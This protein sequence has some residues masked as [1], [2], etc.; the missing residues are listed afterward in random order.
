MSEKSGTKVRLL[1]I[2]SNPGQ[3]GDC[4][5]ESF[6]V[7]REGDG[8]QVYSN[9]N[10]L[11]RIFFIPCNQKVER[12]NADDISCYGNTSGTYYSSEIISK[13]R[14][15]EMVV[16]RKLLILE[17][18]KSLSC[19]ILWRIEDDSNRKIKESVWSICKEPSLI[20]CSIT[21]RWKHRQKQRLA[22]KMIVVK[23]YKSAFIRMLSFISYDIRISTHL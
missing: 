13:Q 19:T 23:V 5:K 10:C 15:M 8:K 7:C 2:I 3:P 12:A 18:R 1:L 20:I 21:S 9:R 17:S 11:Y 14:E 4:C 16:T 6:L 22:F